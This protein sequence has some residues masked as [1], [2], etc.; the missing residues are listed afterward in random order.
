M[1]GKAAVLGRGARLSDYLS[2]G[3]LA[4][5]ISPSAVQ[6][7]LERAGRQS[8]RNRA[9]PAAAVV[10]YVIALS[11]Y[12][13]VN[14]QEVLR[15]VCEGLD[16]L[17][18][19]APLSDVGKSGISQARTRLGEAVMQEIAR[20]VLQP[21]GVAPDGKN[22]KANLAQTSPTHWRGLRVVALDGSTV[23][24]TDEQDN[25]EAFGVPGTQ[26]GRTG[27]PQARFTALFE[28]GSGALFG[29]TLGGYKNSEHSLAR[30]T[31]ISLKSDM[32]CLAD[33][34][35]A[36]YPLWEYANE[37]KAQLLWRIPKNRRLPKLQVLADGSFL[38][39]LNISPATHLTHPQ[40]SGAPIK[41]RVIEY[42]LPGRPDSEPIYRLITT[43]LDAKSYPADELAAL[44]AERWGIETAFADLKTTLK[45]ADIVLRS[46]TPE[47]VRQEFWGMM[48]AYQAVRLL[49]WEVAQTNRLAPDKLSFKGA[50]NTVR[51]KLPRSGA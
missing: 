50:L 31:I 2:V 38:S 35:F 30:H 49:M 1:A 24:V 47:L 33:R 42:S 23:E 32:L 37:T 7:A 46:K 44:Y 39:E 40:L 34:G 3:L 11:L 14:A 6:S 21:M 18:C 5:M 27:Y 15:V 25:R 12:R 8:Q 20:E 19:P 48:L 28:R 13:S 41:V 51:R 29:V 9:F 36:G 22:A 4:R 16:Y 43:L 26:Q 17:D 45:G 10:Y